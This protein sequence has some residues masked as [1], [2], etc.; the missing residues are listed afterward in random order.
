[1]KLTVID[2]FAGCGGFSHGLEQA[3]FTVI[4]FVEWWKPAIATFLKNHPE[5]TLI[6]T[7]ITKVPDEALVKYKDKVDLIVGGPPCQ[8]FS[9]CGKRDLQDTRNQLYK[10]FLRFV[11]IIK[12]KTVIMENVSG[13]LSMDDGNNKKVIDRI[14]HDFIHLGYMISYRVL[15]ASDYG[16]AQNR[17]RLIIIGHHKNI[18]PKP[19]DGKKSV[20]EAIADVPEDSNAHLFFKTIK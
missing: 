19:R 9:M 20:M 14:L 16:V 1:M 13:L 10:E 7:D 15:T 12:P 18:F 11:R 5:A 17:K 3:G 8:G 2:L 6:G 4:G